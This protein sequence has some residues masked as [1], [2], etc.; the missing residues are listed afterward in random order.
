MELVHSPKGWLAIFSDQTYIHVL[1]T[2]SVGTRCTRSIDRTCYESVDMYPQLL[3]QLL[4]G[5]IMLLELLYVIFV[6]HNGSLHCL[7]DFRH[8]LCHLG[9]PIPRLVQVYGAVDL[10]WR[11]SLEVV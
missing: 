7:G 9:G 4:L 11:N 6:D 1:N 5:Q 3:F 2:I 10:V 8:R